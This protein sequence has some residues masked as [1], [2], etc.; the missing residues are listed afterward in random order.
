MLNKKKR[1]TQH[2]RGQADLI[3]VFFDI[4]Q[5]SHSDEFSKTEGQTL[6]DS[7]VAKTKYRGETGWSFT[8]I[9]W[10]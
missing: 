4:L 10:P 5:Y 8:G 1:K 9:F 6:S 3:V 7:C 2:I